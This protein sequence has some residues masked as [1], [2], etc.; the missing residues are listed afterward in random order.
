MCE[1][2]LEGGVVTTWLSSRLRARTVTAVRNASNDEW[3]SREMTA[4]G[5]SAG[6]Q[7]E[8]GSSSLFTHNFHLTAVA[9]NPNIDVLFDYRRTTYV[10]S[11]K[12]SNIYPYG[13]TYCRDNLR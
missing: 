13:Y 1:D 6:K 7:N 10:D 5:Y 9:K 4:V 12:P 8:S 3:L 11:L 2:D